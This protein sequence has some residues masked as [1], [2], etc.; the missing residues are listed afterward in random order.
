MSRETPMR[1]QAQ[2]SSR[3][4]TYSY[5]QH[6]KQTRGMMGDHTIRKGAGVEVWKPSWK[7]TTTTLRVYPA[8]APEN[9]EMWDPWRF[10]AEDDD[11]GDWLRTYPAVRNFGD[12]GV[13]FILNDPS[14]QGYDPQTNPCWV[15]YNAVTRA[16]A[17][18]QA[19]PQWV[20]LTLGSQGRGAALKRPQDITLIQGAILQHNNKDFDPPRG[21]AANDSTVLIELSGSAVRAMLDAMNERRPDFRGD[22]TDYQGAYVHGDP[23]DIHHGAFV[24]F[25]QL[26]ADPRERVS[27]AAQRGSSFGQARPTTAQG[28]GRGND[29]PIGFGCFLSRD[30]K[31]MPPQLTAVE[32]LVRR[33]WKPWDDIIQILNHED[34]IRLLSGAFPADMIIYALEG[35]YRDMIPDSVWRSYQNRS[36]ATVGGAVPYGAPAQP[37]GGANAGRRG[38]GAPAPDADPSQGQQHGDPAQ[39]QYGDPAQ[40]QYGDPVQGQ[41]YGEQAPQYQAPQVPQAP[42]YAPPQHQAPQVPQY[43]PP[44]TPPQAPQAP[45]SGFGG[46]APTTPPQTNPPA[47]RRGF[48]GTAPVDGEVTQG[49]AVPRAELPETPPAAQTPPA[50]FDPRPA[51]GGPPATGNAV[52]DAIR[53]AR[54]RVTNKASRAGGAPAG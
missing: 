22:P 43:V 11:Y 19:N 39:G 34:Q 12:P 50:G 30:Y 20:P 44:Q 1:G 16:I 27:S 14:D 52:Q 24:N 8:L 13:T 28:G 36:V 33:K 40:G 49:S 45:R 17:A 51:A 35:L 5:G 47:G 46:A 48:G 15:L 37:Q 29:E 23:L 6:G 25:Y 42:Q 21:G 10:S 26:G 2:A 18:G 3:A 38:W 7:A 41:P 32:E 54:Q 4:R 53:A 31:G 9:P